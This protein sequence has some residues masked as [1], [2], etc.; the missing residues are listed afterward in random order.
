M[1]LMNNDFFSKELFEKIQNL[2]G[3][4][5]I[6]DRVYANG[7]YHGLDGAWHQ[8]NM[9]PRAW[10]FLIYLNEVADQ[11]LDM[12]GGT[13]DFKETD[14]A[15]KSIQPTSNSGILFMS[16]IFHRGMSPSRF[17]PDMRVTLA[18][19]LREMIN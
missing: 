18:W 7:Q 19:K 10:T 5:L 17:I 6:L 14:C 2:V 4:R 3:A 11:D 1:D 13:T 16:N 9:D 12:Y 15:F 8:D